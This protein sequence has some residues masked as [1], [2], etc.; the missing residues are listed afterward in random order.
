MKKLLLAGLLFGS[1]AVAQESYTVL[2]YAGYMNYTGTTT[3][4]N[5]VVG[6]V[7]LSVFESP[8]KT[9]VDA[10]HTEIKY[11]DPIPKLIQTDLTLKV[12][13]YEGYN[14]AYNLGVHY[15]DTSDALTDKAL[16]YMAG[17]SYYKTLQY[18]VGVDLYYSD[19]SHL[20]TSPR[21]YQVS[22]KAGI[23]F[24][25]YNSAIGS[26]YFETK[27]DYIRTGKNK[28]VNSLK[29]SYTSVELTLNNYNGNFTTSISGWGGKRSYAVENGGFIVNN[30]GN[31]QLSG[32]K[33]SESYKFNTTQSLKLEYSYIKFREVENTDAKSNTIL[34]SY[35][36]SF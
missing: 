12:N 3:K 36:Y 11:Q 4:D 33:V 31:E 25:N 10:E 26:F 19:Y 28:E 1:V 7:Y 24:G 20:K 29:T 27:V 30:I 35:S 22:P 13:Y 8:W 2:P 34:A 18:N 32:F 9:E 16:I 6:G 21:I 5:G 23:N 17:I 14:L 15:I